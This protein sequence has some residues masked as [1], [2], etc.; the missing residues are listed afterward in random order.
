MNGIVGKVNTSLSKNAKA[1]VGS[2]LDPQRSNKEYTTFKNVTNT[3]KDE[4]FKVKKNWR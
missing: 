2:S 1:S 3:Y 4:P